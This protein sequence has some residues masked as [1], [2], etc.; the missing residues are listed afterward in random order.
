MN[1][2]NSRATFSVATFNVWQCVATFSVWQQ[3]VC[4][5]I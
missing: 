4:G 1:G 3:L 2:G 5:N